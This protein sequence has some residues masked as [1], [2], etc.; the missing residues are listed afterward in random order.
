MILLLFFQPLRMTKTGFFACSLWAVVYDSH[1]STQNT[2]V[3]IPQQPRVRLLRPQTLSPQHPSLVNISPLLPLSYKMKNSF[4]KCA[5]C[6]KCCKGKALPCGASDTDGE[7]RSKLTEGWWPPPP[8]V[9]LPTYPSNPACFLT[10]PSSHSISCFLVSQIP[11][12]T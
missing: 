2:C 9:T 10:R 3:P 5:H 4:A 7:A 8:F 12:P 11:S 6:T 1:C